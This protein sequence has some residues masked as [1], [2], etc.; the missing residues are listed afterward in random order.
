MSTL[1]PGFFN[2]ICRNLV[3]SNSPLRCLS[4]SSVDRANGK[5]TVKKTFVHYAFKLIYH[6]NMN[7][8]C[9]YC[10]EGQ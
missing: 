5:C 1:S 10:Q 4:I 3:R 9:S 8:L 7:F 2:K 6:L